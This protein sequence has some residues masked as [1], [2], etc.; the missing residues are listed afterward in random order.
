MKIA[1]VIAT[2][3]PHHGGMGYV[4]YHNALELARRG[5]EVTVFTL[6]HGR[7]SYDDDPGEFKIVRLRTPMM[8]GDGGIVPQLFSGLKGFDIIH[9]HYPFF[10]GE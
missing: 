6:D 9:L 1:E 3:P 7:Q 8:Y 4:C 2:F 5:H 10:G